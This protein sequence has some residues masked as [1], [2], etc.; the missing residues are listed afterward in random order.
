MVRRQYTLGRMLTRDIFITLF[1]T[2]DILF[3]RL[4]ESGYG[5]HFHRQP[6]RQMLSWF[7]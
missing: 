3:R 1:I 4:G 5:F 6:Y 2:S 7:A